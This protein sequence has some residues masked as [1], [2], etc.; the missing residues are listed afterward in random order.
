MPARAGNVPK[1]PQSIC[2]APMQP[3]GVGRPLGTHGVEVADRQ[4]GH[5]GLVDLG[6]ERH[7]A[8]HVGVAGLVHDETVREL[9]DEATGTPPST[10]VPSSR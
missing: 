1:W 8:E 10:I 9:E 6:D 7:V 4:D 2:F 5:V 3:H